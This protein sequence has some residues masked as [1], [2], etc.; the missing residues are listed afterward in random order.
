MSPTPGD[1]PLGES[2]DSLIPS[3]AALYDRFAHALN[4]FSEARDEAER[5]FHSEVLI[6]YD[7][8][9]GQKPSFQEYRKG[10]ILRCKRYLAANDKPTSPP[11]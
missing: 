4:P 10:V 2:D 8:I 11:P 6:A 5:V 3:L 9:K 7:A 1:A